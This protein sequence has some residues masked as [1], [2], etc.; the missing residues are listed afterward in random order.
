[1]DWKLPFTW[2]Q[3]NLAN[4]MGLEF[5]DLS[6]PWGLGQ[7]CWPY[8]EDVKIER[9]HGMSKSGVLTQRITTVMHSGTHIDAPAHVVEGTPFMD[10]VPLPYFFGSGVVVSIPKNKWEVI[11]ADDLEKARP[12]IREGD[13]VVVNTG[14]HKYYGDNQIYYGYSPGFYKEA[15]E[16]FVERKVKMCGSDTQALDHP[17][18][19]AIGPH[20]PG[21]PNGLLPHLGPE[22]KAFSG[23]RSIIEDFPYWEPCHRAILSAGICGFENIGGEIDKVTGKRVTFAAFP[24][25]WT[26]GDG[27]IVR[28]VA[29]LDPTGNFRIES[30]KSE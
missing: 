13:I 30:G 16:W 19:T 4:S 14:W 22:Y 27:C 10:E 25:R 21:A 5:Y 18:G 3:Q 26:R 29:I 20:G 6:H 7:P 28:L 12:Q 15:G 2:S 9:L 8:F 23:G 11:T 17:L 24:W 1:M